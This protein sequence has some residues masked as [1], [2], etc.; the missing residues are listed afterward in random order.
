MVTVN[1]VFRA[2]QAQGCADKGARTVRTDAAGLARVAEVLGRH[3]LDSATATLKGVDVTAYRNARK[4]AGVSPK[5]ILRELAVASAACRWAISE[6]DMDIVNPFAGRM[7]SKQD[8][9]AMQPAGRAIS[10]EEA[11]RLVLAADQPMADIIAFVLETGLRETEVRL[12][13]RDRIHGQLVVFR[14]EHQKSGRAGVRALSAAAK[15]IV[16]RLPDSE[17]LF[18]EGDGRALSENRF[19]YLWRVA[20]K[21]ARVQCRFHDLRVTAATRMRER[22]V[23]IADIA[24]QLGN[25]IPVAEKHYAQAGEQAVLR[26]VT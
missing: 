19:E 9:K 18:H 21:R 11:S 6:A 2:Y 24:A 16:D 14:P 12:L 1:D 23:T 5:T 26:A 10:Q 8:R 3:A 7:I 4:A 13:T 15:A 25:T 22:G 17:Y 20:R